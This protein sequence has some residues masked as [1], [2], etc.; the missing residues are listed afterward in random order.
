MDRLKER[1][2]KNDNCPRCEHLDWNVDL[3]E[4][5]GRSAITSAAIPILA[6]SDPQAGYLS[7]L[8]VVCRNCGYTMFHNLDI[9]GISVE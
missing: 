7:M 8:A 9:L 5:P 6:S 2:V 3:V 1:G 4:I